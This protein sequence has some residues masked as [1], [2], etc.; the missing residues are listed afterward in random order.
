MKPD[1]IISV[2][3]FTP[4]EG[5]RRTAIE[6]QIYSCPLLIDG[7]GYDCRIFLEGRRLDLG[8]TFELPV[9]FLYRDLA[10]NHIA[11]EKE[12]FLW[13]GKKIAKGKV[14]KIFEG[15]KL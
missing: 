5:G 7:E 15:E 14:I 1:A 6:G 3:F 9:R 13:E 12:I 8:K 2:R 11:L 10:L 4:L